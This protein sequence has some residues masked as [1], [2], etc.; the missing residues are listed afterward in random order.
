MKMRDKIIGEMFVFFRTGFRIIR[1]D[2]RGAKKANSFSKNIFIECF[3]TMSGFQY[4]FIVE[5]IAVT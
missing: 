4:F 1:G 3:Q 5:L 2:I